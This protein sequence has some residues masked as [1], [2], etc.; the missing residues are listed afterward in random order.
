M[1]NFKVIC[2]IL[3]HIESQMD[4]DEPDMSSMSAEA[5]GISESRRKRLIGLLYQNGFIESGPEIT[6]KGLEYLEN[7]R[8]FT[9][10]IK[11]SGDISH[12][13]VREWVKESIDST[14]SS[15]NRKVT[16]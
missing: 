13:K 6:L 10:N 11:I 12:E 4:C 3:R 7:H 16:D 14:F 5:L 1:D 15:Y 8:E 9:P 2:K